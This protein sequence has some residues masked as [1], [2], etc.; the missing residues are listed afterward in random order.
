MEEV[1]TAKNDIT[2]DRITVKP[3]TDAFR[4]GWDRIFN[5]QVLILEDESGGVTINMGL[6]PAIHLS[7]KHFNALVAAILEIVTAEQI[8]QAITGE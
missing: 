4:E 7:R 5:N 6:E 1:M 3:T 8:Q 2:G